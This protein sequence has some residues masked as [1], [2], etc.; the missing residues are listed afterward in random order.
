VGE[1]LAGDLRFPSLLPSLRA[2]TDSLVAE[3]MRRAKGNQTMAAKFLGI[4]PQAVSKRLK[5]RKGRERGVD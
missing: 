4:S 5:S 2:M 1:E 3:A